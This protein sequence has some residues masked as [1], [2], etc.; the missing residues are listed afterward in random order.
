MRA[1][2]KMV[3]ATMTGLALTFF[4][5]I[6]VFAGIVA[7]AVSS[8]KKT[9]EIGEQTVLEFR[10]GLSIPDR[11]IENPLAS[12]TDE[13]AFTVSLGLY[14][15]LQSIERAKTDKRIK[16][17]VLRPEFSGSGFATIAELRSKIAE[18]R[19][20]GK[21]VYCY[22]DVMTEQ[23]FYLASACDSIFIHPSCEWMFDGLS[24]NI[25]MYKGMLD[26]AGVEMEVFR[27]GKYKSA[28]EPF[29]QKQISAENREQTNLMVQTV[30]GQYIRDIARSRNI[31]SATLAGYAHT[32]AITDA[33]TAC[34]LRLADRRL[35]Y[36]QFIEIA[37]RKAGL[38]EP[39]KL[40]PLPLAD[41]AAS[42]DEDDKDYTRDKIAIVYASGEIGY[43]KSQEPDQITNENMAT[44]LRKVRE[45]K[46]IKA[47]VLRVNSPGGGSLASDIIAREIELTRK[48][49]PVIAS[50]GN[51]AASGG[52]YIACLADTIVCLPQTITGSIGVFGLFPNTG[53]LFRE[54]LGLAYESVGTGENSDFGRP[55]GPMNAAQRQYIQAMV[56]RIYGDFVSIVARGRNM[57]TARVNALGQ[58]RV[59]PGNEALRN[60]LADINGG[61]EKALQVAADR[62]KLKNYRVVEYPE[63]KF[64]LSAFF[65]S[66]TDTEARLK[67]M[68]GNDYSFIME[69]RKMTQRSGYQ[70]MMPFELEWR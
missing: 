25:V 67:A 30:F 40:K 20:S 39:A 31:D 58:G 14:D 16:G 1:F 4:L 24:A 26:K 48:V 34:S 17:I 37:G 66:I 19:K 8:G 11:S 65:G 9:A 2:L 53:K 62:A 54:H 15:I 41:Y 42:P 56:N 45:D 38:K 29:I 60:G 27:A 3:L 32:L 57:D 7:T 6:L 61:M 18:F 28:V 49:K 63:V 46:N 23:A 13:S 43:G 70:A 5:L 68:L 59:W 64:S 10:P 69:M 12:F 22:A 47:V 51:V 44:A 35:P 55:D 21:F 36:D 33:A 50:F 52:Y